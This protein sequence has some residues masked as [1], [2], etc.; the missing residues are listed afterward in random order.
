FPRVVV[1]LGYNRTTTLALAA[2]PFVLCCIV[3]LIMV[4]RSDRTGERYCHIVFPLSVTLVANIIAVSTLS[5]A[6]RYIAMMLMPP[7]FYAAFAV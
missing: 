1:T 5:T 3:I 6:G 2:P 7:S 4:F